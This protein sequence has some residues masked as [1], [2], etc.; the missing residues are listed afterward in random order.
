MH[1]PC[2][3]PPSLSSTF[4]RNL[5]GRK[6]NFNP[7]STRPSNLFLTSAYDKNQN[8]RVVDESMI[9]LRMRIRD[10]KMA[11]SNEDQDVPENWME[12]DKTYYHQ[13]YSSDITN[14]VGKLQQ[15]L[16]ETRPS[17]ALGM[18]VLVLCS[19]SYSMVMAVCMLIDMAKFIIHIIQ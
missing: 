3:R 7:K 9:V 2:L 5:A 17:L 19:L 1:S 10:I 12:W 15:I 8:G 14:G 6:I 13:S 18:L 11:E 16:M 4:S